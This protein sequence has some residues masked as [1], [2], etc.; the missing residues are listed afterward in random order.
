MIVLRA[1]A[2]TLTVRTARDSRVKLLSGLDLTLEAGRSIAITGRSGSGKTT[3]LSVLGMLTRPDD[4]SLIIADEDVTRNSDCA[5][6]AWRN[7]HIGFIFQSYSLVR[8]LSAYRNVELPLTYGRSVGR[9]DRRQ[10]VPGLLDQVGLATRARS[11][12][13]HL[14]GGEQQRVAIAR[15]LVRRPAIILADEPT[16][17]LDVETGGTVL[18]LLRR[19]CRE[20]GAGL[21]LVTHD[22]EV[23]ATMDRVLELREGRLQPCF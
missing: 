22:A 6:A 18:S 9:R 11:R 21:I 5:R 7:A 2:L 13:R 4:G 19:T 20:A 12:P 1:Q 8:H 3:L 17:A 10:R 16:G 15:A 23:A 14:S